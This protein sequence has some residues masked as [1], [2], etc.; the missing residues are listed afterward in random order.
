MR[1]IASPA[2]FAP[3]RLPPLFFYLFVVRCLYRNP[4][5]LLVRVIR[6]FKTAFHHQTLQESL[7][8][9]MALP[10]AKTPT[11]TTMTVTKSVQSSRDR[12]RPNSSTRI[13]RRVL[14]DYPLAR[15]LVDQR[16]FIATA[17]AIDVCSYLAKRLDV[18]LTRRSVR[19]TYIQSS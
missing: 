2:L 5:S 12:E 7:K 9:A 6:G 15:K 3:L 11:T 4:F 14:M 16:E 19:L 17:F 13:V 8:K 1:E 10:P 18:D